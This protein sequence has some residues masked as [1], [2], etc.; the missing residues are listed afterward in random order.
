M[1]LRMATY[2]IDKSAT[3]TLSSSSGPS[4]C[5]AVGQDNSFDKHLTFLLKFP[6]SISTPGVELLSRTISD[7]YRPLHVTSCTD[8][9]YDET[10]N[11]VAAGEPEVLIQ[12]KRDNLVQAIIG[13][14]G[15]Q[16]IKQGD[17]AVHFWPHPTTDD[18]S[19]IANQVENFLSHTADLQVASDSV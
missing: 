2:G 4:S 1:E 8:D 3:E 15:I 11:L 6:A 14:H 10:G 13:V 12:W 7:N 5:S 16:I 17:S 18:T 9:E 19:K